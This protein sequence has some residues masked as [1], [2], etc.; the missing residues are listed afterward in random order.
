MDRASAI[1]KV[2]EVLL[3]EGCLS[4]EE[5]INLKLEQELV[6]DLGFDSLERIEF[7]M[8]LEEEFMVEISDETI[9]EWRTVEDVVRWVEEQGDA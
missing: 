5:I 9:D 4:N 1:E 3:H 6:N 7:A 2:K 8:A